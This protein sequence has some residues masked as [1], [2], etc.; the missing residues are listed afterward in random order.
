MDLWI[1]KLSKSGFCEDRFLSE[2]PQNK[3]FSKRISDFKKLTVNPNKARGRLSDEE[4][5]DSKA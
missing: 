5:L 4:H 2:Q 3:A 1:N